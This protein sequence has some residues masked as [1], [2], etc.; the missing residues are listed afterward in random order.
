MDKETLFKE[1]Q[2][3]EVVLWAGSGLSLYAGYPLGKGVVAKLYEALPTSQRQQMVAEFAPQPPLEVALPKFAEMFLTL[4]NE[5]RYLLNRVLLDIFKA[6][7]TSMT[8]HQKL[9]SIPFIE[10]IITTNYENLFEQTFQPLNVVYDSSMLPLRNRRHPTLYK[11]HGHIED[12]KSLIVAERDYQRFFEKADQLLW[13]HLESLM[14]TH[15]LLFI[16]YAVEDPNV[17]DVFLRV[18][19]S[20]G[21][22]MRPA[23][24]VS[25]TITPARLTAFERKGIHYIQATGEQFVDELLADI[26]KNA[27][28]ALKKGLISPEATGKHLTKQGLAYDFRTTENGTDCL[29]IRRKEGQT[30]GKLR[31]NLPASSD[32]IQGLDKLRAGESLTAVQ[33]SPEQI[34]DLSLQ[35]EGFE[36]PVEDVADGLWFVRRPSWQ[37]RVTLRF[38]GG[39]E[40]PNVTVK[41]Y[42]IK[43]GA[44]QIIAVDPLNRISIGF[45]PPPEGIYTFSYDLNY[46][47]RRP[48][49]D[50]VGAGLAIARTMLTIGNGEA[51]EVIEN[52]EVIGRFPR[53]QVSPLADMGQDLQAILQAL[54]RIEQGFDIKFQHFTLEGQKLDEIYRLDELLRLE[55][56]EYTWTGSVLA[57][58]D[59]QNEMTQ[60]IISQQGDGFALESQQQALPETFHILGWT[61]Q[62]SYLEMVRTHEP[63]TIPKGNGVFEITSRN[64]LLT[65]QLLQIIDAKV[66][67]RPEP[68]MPIPM[69]TQQHLE[70]HLP[71]D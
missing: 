41:G 6:A 58:L 62:L 22:N 65:R 48:G 44:V 24:V 16:G 70:E 56:L 17:L 47:K 55:V 25:P 13:R 19:E 61:L 8:V 27:I 49:F 69:T 7:P 26:K 20:L 39:L 57:Y 36:M 31:F 67:E 42:P 12:T 14:A 15:T 71:G 4:Q 32:F 38:S 64:Q 50:S 43:D 37:K 46:S 11:V 30:E 3:Q 63:I 34:H 52:Y 28:P 33:L 68:A 1:I 40:L 66:L 53:Q 5:S 54:E 51:L 60:R 10:H 35:I 9:A 45:T 18:R 59:E 23:Y 2:Q 29:S 21:P